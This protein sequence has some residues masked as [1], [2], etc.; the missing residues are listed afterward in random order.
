[1]QSARPHPVVHVAGTPPSRL[2]R[3]WAVPPVCAP[4]KGVRARAGRVAATRAPIAHVRRMFPAC[5]LHKKEYVH[6]WGELPA[7]A[8]PPCA[9]GVSSPHACGVSFIKKG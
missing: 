2:V 7:R 6:V 5:A 8:P 1:T 9:C 4:E 3:A